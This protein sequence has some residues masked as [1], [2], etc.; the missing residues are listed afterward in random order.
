MQWR[1][2]L[3][4]YNPELIY[5]QGFKNIAADVLS[6]L[7]IVD[8]DNPI[9]PNMS[10][11]VD[12][13][14]S[15]KNVPHSVNQKTIMQYQQNNKSLI[16]TTNLN[17]DNSFY[18]LHWADK[19]YSLICRMYKIVAHKQLGKQVIEWYYNV[20]CHLRKTC[21]KLFIVQHFH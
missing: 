14:S 8:T 12:N 21:T 7:D 2:I 16:E 6:R 15:E 13:F 18:H 19:K 20:L 3:N 9:K 5:I 10:S 1:F 17:K 4:E 11:L